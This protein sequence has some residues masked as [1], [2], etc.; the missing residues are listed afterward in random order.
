MSVF[1]ENKKWYKSKTMW[2]NILIVV[3]GVATALAGEIQT[4]GTITLLGTM[5]LVL[6]KVTKA[7][8]TF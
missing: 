2:A 8:I 4:G 1:Q 7:G 5:N 3:G 6:R